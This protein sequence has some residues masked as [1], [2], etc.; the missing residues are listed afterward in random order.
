MKLFDPKSIEMN[1]QG[2]KSEKQIKEIKEAIKPGMWLYAGLGILVFGGCFYSFAASASSS[3][4]GVFGWIIVMIG[5]FAMMRGFT[6]W[7]LR[8]KLLAEPVQSAEGT[9]SIN[10]AAETTEGLALAPQGLAGLK[11]SLPPG[12]YRFFFLKTRS[13]LLS[14]EPLSSEEEL[15]N[16]LNE[17][18][19]AAIGYDKSQLTEFRKQ[20]QD[21]TLKT[22]QGEPKLDTHQSSTTVQEQ[23]EQHET[24]VTNYSCTLGEIKFDISNETYS[25]ILN[26]IAY[27][28]Y[29]RAGETSVTAMEVV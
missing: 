18:L 26:D 25:A 23:G 6:T 7:N 14:A 5:L 17:A 29:Y 20:A 1:K 10:F 22:M 19:A 15:R 4:V 8:R 3:G 24:A 12:D 2:R 27:R 21:G 11:A 28:I 16:G 9:V 13:Y